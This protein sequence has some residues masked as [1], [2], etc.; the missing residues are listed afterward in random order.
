VRRAR[1]VA[2]SEGLRTLWFRVL[3]E[4]VYRRLV[5]MERPFG[6]PV[7][8][9]VH[10][11]VPVAFL[12]PEEIGEYLELRPDAPAGELATRFDRGHVCLVA[13]RDGR[14]IAACWIGLGKT[15]IDALGIW[16]ELEPDAGYIYD[17]YVA[18]AA[19]GLNVY[20]RLFD[21]IRDHYG[22]ESETRVMA[23]ATPENRTQRL[24]ER[25]G[26]ESVTMLRTLRLGRWRV[27]SCRFPGKRLFSVR[28][29]QRVTR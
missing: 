27:V 22:Y 28:R 5:V 3:G 6:A 17:L 2:R 19:R 15:W 13:R 14:L 24:F 23:T 16:I 26:C 8:R 12:Q 25:L 18:P 10:Q 1:E 29:L 4:T 11:E 20:L 9:S 7:A 21:A